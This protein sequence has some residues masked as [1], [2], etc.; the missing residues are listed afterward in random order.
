ML[1]VRAGFVAFTVTRDARDTQPTARAQ[2]GVAQEGRPNTSSQ[3]W[4]IPFRVQEAAWPRYAQ[5]VGGIRLFAGT[6][7]FASTCKPGEAQYAGE[8]VA[9]ASPLAIRTA[10]LPRGA[11][12]DS[13]FSESVQCAGV[14][15]LIERFFLI[16][17]EP[18]VHER[19]A[20]GTASWFDVEHG[21]FYWITRMRLREPVWGG[22]EVPSDQWTAGTVAGHSAAIGNPILPGFGYS[23]VAVWDENSGVLTAVRANDR[24]IQEVLNVAAELLK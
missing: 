17:S 5:T 24:P 10:A 23:A 3:G 21:G 12:L 16:P 1:A 4:A 18:G 22:A 11:T 13:A 2:E 20:A 14:V 9:D 19:V 7:D 6:D 15:T 8:A